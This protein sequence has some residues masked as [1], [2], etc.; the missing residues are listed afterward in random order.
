MDMQT[1]AKALK[2]MNINTENAIP[3]AMKKTN[4]GR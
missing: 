1:I 4:G 3:N 2:T